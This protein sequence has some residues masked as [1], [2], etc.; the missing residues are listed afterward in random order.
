MPDT[1]RILAIDYGSKRIGLAVTD[2]LQMI[3]SALD[4]VANADAL[5]YL[6]NYLA[7]EPVVAFVI[8]MP[9]GLDGQATDATAGTLA[10]VR[11]L[12]ETFPDCPIHEVD[13]RFSSKMAE[14][15]MRQG[16]L[17]KKARRDKAQVDRIS[18][19][20]LLQSFLEQRH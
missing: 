12:R 19:V 9:K 5:Q 16:G 3:A 7:Q 4:T 6:K 18:A 15:A 11:K 20:I 17:K 2:P 14:Q 10:F 8:G 1:G 13:E